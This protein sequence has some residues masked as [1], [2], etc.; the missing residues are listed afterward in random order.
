MQG[1]VGANAIAF[2]LPSAGAARRGAWSSKMQPLP[3]GCGFDSR[4]MVSSGPRNERRSA[5]F[6]T[7]YP[8]PSRLAAPHRVP[9]AS[10]TMET[11]QQPRI[12]F[13]ASSSSP[14]L[15]SSS[16]V[17]LGLPTG[18]LC[19][20]FGSKGDLS[21]VISS[22]SS[23]EGFSGSPDY[24]AQHRFQTISGTYGS[25]SGKLTRSPST[26]S[27]LHSPLHQAPPLGPQ[28]APSWSFAAPK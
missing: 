28:A 11:L 2:G 5:P 19:R 4:H 17:M 27:G 25:F 26:S 7:A 13:A 6:G 21:S 18:S 12:P 9:T 24:L 15:R 14:T 23:H 3:K 8:L 20:P 1:N 22:G 10:W 16:S